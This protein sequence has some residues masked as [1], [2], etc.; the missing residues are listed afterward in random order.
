MAEK[1]HIDKIK[2][3]SY[4]NIKGKLT[5][6]NIEESN[7]QKDTSKEEIEK[8]LNN[9]KKDKPREEVINRKKKQ[10]ELLVKKRRMYETSLIVAIIICVLLVTLIIKRAVNSHCTSYQHNY[11]SQQVQAYNAEFE[12]YE[13]DNVRGSDVRALINKINARNRYNAAEPSLQIQVTS[14]GTALTTVYTGAAYSALNTPPNNFAVAKAYTVKM[15]YNFQSGYIVGVDIVD[16][17]INNENNAEKQNE[18]DY[19]SN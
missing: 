18:I 6:E 15:G 10:L 17:T 4:N 1:N 16:N 11:L 3:L 5:M 2:S 7:Y 13:G 19:N 12:A 9:L 8:V 14:D